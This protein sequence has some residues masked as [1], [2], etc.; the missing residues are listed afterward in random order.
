MKRAIW[1]PTVT[2]ARQ[3]LERFFTWQR[4]DEKSDDEHDAAQAAWLVL[5]EEEPEPSDVERAAVAFVE[6]VDATQDATSLEAYSDLAA[7]VR[8]LKA[9]P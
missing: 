4:P 1:F 8:A 3:T 6:A 5:R 7:A 9:R 2:Q